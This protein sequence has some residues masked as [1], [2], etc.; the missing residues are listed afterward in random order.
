MS[1]RMAMSRQ[2]KK[3]ISM[4][5][6]SIDNE[7]RQAKEPQTSTREEDVKKRSRSRTSEL[8]IGGNTGVTVK[9]GLNES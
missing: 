1:G 7:F 5:L 3:T 4:S 8:A 2:K 6:K 9:K